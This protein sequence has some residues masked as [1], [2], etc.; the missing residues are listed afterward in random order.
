M[1]LT[2]AKTSENR[3]SS[4]IEAVIAMGVLA[5]AIPL[6]FGALAESGRSN[7]SSEAETRSTW[8]VPACME[9]ILASREGKPRFFTAT[10]VG[11]IFPPAGDVWALAFSAEGKPIGKISKS[12]YDKGT[13][14]VNGQTVRYIATLSSATTTTPAG[15]TPMLRTL[16]SLEYP[17]ALPVAKRQKLEFHTRIP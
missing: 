13:K 3:G 5:V 10:T 12:V 15:A 4:L 17:S 7:V 1:N 16:I 9:E 14:D 8:I 2:A 6:V 11:Q